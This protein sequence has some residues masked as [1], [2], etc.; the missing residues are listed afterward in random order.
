MMT[1]LE[2]KETISQC[3]FEDWLIE[4]KTDKDRPY[5]QIHVLNGKDSVTGGPLE[6]TSRKWMLSY[7]MVKNEI[8]RTAFKAVMTAMQHEV[9]E[10][11]KYKGVSIYNPHIDPDK[12]VDF[13]NNSANVQIRT[14]VEFGV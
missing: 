4:V 12:L 11:F 10:G 2:I 3:K 5:I 14:N 6:W 9:E 1:L 13:A 7:H 8:V